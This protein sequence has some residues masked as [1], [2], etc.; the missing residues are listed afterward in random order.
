MIKVEVKLVDL[1]SDD[2]PWCTCERYDTTHES[3][4]NPYYI[5]ISD[6]EYEKLKTESLEWIQHYLEIPFETDL[7]VVGIRGKCYDLI[8]YQ[9][10]TSIFP[11]HELKDPYYILLKTKKYDMLVHRDDELNF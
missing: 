1:V 7:S 2:E 6:E 3:E 8:K 4:E 9:N 10:V 11:Q 5:L